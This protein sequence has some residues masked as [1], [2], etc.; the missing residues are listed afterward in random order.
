[1]I[2]SS[3]SAES[4]SFTS[5][6]SSLPLSLPEGGEAQRSGLW[7]YH[8]SLNLYSMCM[9][10]MVQSTSNHEAQLAR[11]ILHK[12]ALMLFKMAEALYVLNIMHLQTDCKTSESTTC[13]TWQP[14]YRWRSAA[15]ACPPGIPQK[16][17]K[18]NGQKFA[19]ER[20]Y[21]SKISFA[22]FFR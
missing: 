16:D 21:C 18:A 14:Y 3:C 13:H 10:S 5:V 20:M 8:E 9:Y 12:G 19:T 6:P 4:M 7:R 15:R 22:K 2:L 17:G 11:L 1:M